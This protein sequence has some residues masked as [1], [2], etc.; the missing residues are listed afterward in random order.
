MFLF[1]N[2][3]FFVNY[4][5]VLVFIGNVMDLLCILGLF[6]YMI[7]FCLV[8]FV[9]ERCNVKWV[10]LFGVVVVCIVFFGGFN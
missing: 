1:D 4:V 6:M 10:W 3:V 5:I 7:W 2:G 8:C 9:V